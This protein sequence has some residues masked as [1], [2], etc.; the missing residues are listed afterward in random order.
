MQSNLPSS[1]DGLSGSDYD[2][3]EARIVNTK[4]D[5]DNEQRVSIRPEAWQMS[6]SEVIGQRL[7]TNK[8]EVYNRLYVEG[9]SIIRE[10]IGWKD[11]NQLYELR[12]DVLGFVSNSNL[13]RDVATDIQRKL[14]SHTFEFESKPQNT[15]QGPQKV[16]VPDSVLAEVKEGFVDKFNTGQDS[17]H[18]AVL[19]CGFLSSEFA[20]DM[21]TEYS[22]EI[23]QSIYETHKRT[24]RMVER[25]FESYAL[26]CRR[27]WLSGEAQPQLETMRKIHENMESELADTVEDLI[28]ELEN[29]DS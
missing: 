16:P 28:V 25:E 17:F 7:G 11:I 22:E 26:A 27:K 20:G 29:N 8:V 23:L 5:K 12:K 4:R 14:V 21:T 6:E 9:V 3:L 15:V 2:T 1:D 24:R 13:R 19:G 10:T 18:R